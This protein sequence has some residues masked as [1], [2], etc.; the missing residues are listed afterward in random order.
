MIAEKILKN[1]EAFFIRFSFTLKVIRIVVVD[2][3]IAV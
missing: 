3:N 1:C 2:I